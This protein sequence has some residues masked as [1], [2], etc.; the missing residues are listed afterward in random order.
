MQRENRI[1]P[2]TVNIWTLQITPNLRIKLHASG[3]VLNEST[4]ALEMN[5]RMSNR[6]VVLWIPEDYL[7]TYFSVN[8]SVCHTH[9]RLFIQMI[10]AVLLLGATIIS[11]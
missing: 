9:Y 1:T 4:T 8:L 5:S 7:Y 6:S 10:T 2:T 3:S 11:K